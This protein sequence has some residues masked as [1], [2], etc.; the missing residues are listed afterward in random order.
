[1]TAPKGKH[2]FGMVTV[3]EKGQIVIPKKA[4]AIFNINPG[5][6]LMVVGDE[7]SGLAIITSSELTKLFNGIMREEKT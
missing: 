7:S 2:I 4:R 3:G 1:M 6:Q 5:D